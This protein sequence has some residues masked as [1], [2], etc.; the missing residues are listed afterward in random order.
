MTTRVVVFAILAVSATR[1]FAC[2]Y[3][4]YSVVEVA[5]AIKISSTATQIL[6]DA[7]CDF[8]A[9]AQAE[10]G[11]S[12]CAY[13]SKNFGILQLDIDNFPYGLTSDDYLNLPLQEQVDVWASQVGSSNAGRTYQMLA[14]F[15]A[16]GQTVGGTAVTSGM[17]AACFQ[18]GP[19]ICKN[20]VAF[21]QSRGGQCP[22]PSNGGVNIN[23]LPRKRQSEASLD[24]H[25]FSICSWGGPIQAKID[26]FAATC[27]N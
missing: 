23:D 21:M 15:K 9:A 8:G 26:R 14:L 3:P 16:N 24:G 10:S 5:A 2:N 17:L 27:G 4:N 11:G 1:G 25:G 13:N 18:F 22:T 20:D 6:R 19:S 12:T 7:A